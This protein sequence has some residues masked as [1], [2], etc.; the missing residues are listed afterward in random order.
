MP[1]TDYHRFLGSI[2]LFSVNFRR[3]LFDQVF[4][5]EEVAACSW[6]SLTELRT[7]S[8]SGAGSLLAPFKML[9]DQAGSAV[10]LGF[11]SVARLTIRPLLATAHAK[12]A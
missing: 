5:R 2:L 9:L 6:G 3:R 10:V 4:L 1:T 8:I 12:T 7:G 11:A